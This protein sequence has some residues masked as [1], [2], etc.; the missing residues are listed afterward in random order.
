MKKKALSLALALSMCLG[1]TVP[2][3]ANEESPIPTEEGVKNISITAEIGGMSFDDLDVKS[4]YTLRNW[5]YNEEK[6]EAVPADDTLTDYIAVTKNT[7]FT[8]KHTGTVDD[9]TTLRIY[10]TSYI[11][12]GDGIYDWS[13]WPHA[14]T[15]SHSSFDWI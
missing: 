4:N 3:F 13:D 2:A 9:G 5:E 15:N 11:N 7:K 14:A 1:L 10:V 8:V 6:D 12:T